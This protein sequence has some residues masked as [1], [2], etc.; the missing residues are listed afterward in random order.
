MADQHF[1]MGISLSVHFVHNSCMLG[2][3]SKHL[4]L[5]MNVTMIMM[6]MIYSNNDDDDDE[7]DNDDRLVRVEV[8]YLPSATEQPPPVHTL[9]PLMMVMMMMVMMM[10]MKVMIVILM[11]MSLVR[12]LLM[13]FIPLGAL[14]LFA[15]QSSHCDNNL[16]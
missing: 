5:M 6:M 12:L 16:L 13:I 8:V 3:G 1:S 7:H 2:K 4:L 9:V 14:N 15:H 11:V 10:K